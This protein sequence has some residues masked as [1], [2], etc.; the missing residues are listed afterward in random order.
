MGWALVGLTQV[1][2]WVGLG[3]LGR[4]HLRAN[5]G[6]VGFGSAKLG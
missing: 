4:I 2:R 5:P 3:S 6:W 1:L